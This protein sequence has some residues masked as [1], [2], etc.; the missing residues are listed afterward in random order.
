MR[1]ALIGEPLEVKV[2]EIPEPEVQPGFAL[3]RTRASGICGS[4][5][6]VYRGHWPSLANPT[7]HEFC[8]DVI[9]IGEGVTDVEPGQR[10]CVECFS[11][12]GS[13]DMCQLG[14]YNHCANRRFL[15]EHGPG[16]FAPISRVHASSLI[17]L[18]N[19]LSDEDG[20]FV[21]PLAVGVR[22]LSQ[23]D[24]RAP[25]RLAIVGG[26]TIGLCT[27][28][29][30]VANG[31]G[32]VWMS[33]RYPHQVEAARK[34]GVSNP[35]LS[36]DPDGPETIRQ[37]IEEASAGRGVDAIVDTIGTASSFEDAVAIARPGADLSLVGGYTE[38]VTVPLGTV[39]AKE[40]RI[41]GSMCYAFSGERRDF[42]SA[43]ALLASG[44]VQS[45]PLITHRF[46]SLEEAPEAFRVADDKS[47]GSI[48]VQFLL[49]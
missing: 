1:V 23:I 16:G 14:K 5:L 4:D 3:L 25:D 44:R 48:K 26:G 31:F 24:A 45:E 10:V 17:P 20:A 6:H 41:V 12:C 21:E 43:I 30:A 35:V 49:T 22:A 7:G 2:A 9:A 37:A 19:E 46:G 40:L 39:V 29:A 11:H 8:G 47:S 34:I 28:A 33:C 18:P 38:P 15:S 13:C 32:E 27:A 36:G 42:E